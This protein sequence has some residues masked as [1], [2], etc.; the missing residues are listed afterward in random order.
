MD[1]LGDQQEAAY[2][3]S[4]LRPTGSGEVY[5]VVSTLATETGDAIYVGL[6]ANDAAIMGGVPNGTLL[7]TQ[8]KGSA[9]VYASTVDNP[10]N[11][12]VRY[13]SNDCAALTNVPGGE[14]N[15][16]EIGGMSTQGDPDLQDKIILSLRNYIASDGEPPFV[17][18]HG[19]LKYEGDHV[20]L[21]EPGVPGHMAFAW[22]YDG[23]VL[24]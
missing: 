20:I 11:I 24:S 6:S 10:D 9:D 3:F 12:F 22:Q 17:G 19:T 16:T 14:E 1:C 18:S 13:F 7:D 15:C 21:A 23:N 4:A 8:P 2:S 5:A